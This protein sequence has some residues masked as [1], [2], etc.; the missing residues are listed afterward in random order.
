GSGAWLG[1]NSV[2]LPGVRLGRNCGVAAGTVVRP[3]TDA[4]H[5][6]IAGVPGQVVRTYDDEL[7]CAPALQEAAAPPRVPAP[8]PGRP[9]DRPA[10]RSARPRV[11]HPLPARLGSSGAF[12]STDGRCRPSC[13]GTDAGTGVPTGARCVRG[14]DAGTGL[15]KAGPECPGAAMV[16]P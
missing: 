13:S 5:S 9:S 12:A 8:S 3:G 11:G 2:I 15:V 16:G 7:G 1:A 10:C 14:P 6:G 4:D